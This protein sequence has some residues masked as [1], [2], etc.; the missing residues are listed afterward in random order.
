MVAPAHGAASDPPAGEKSPPEP[1]AEEAEDGSGEQAPRSVLV[2][3]ASTGIG[4]ATVAELVGRGWRVWATVRRPEDAQQLV[5]EHGTAVTVLTL[6]L[7]DADAVA[8]AGERVCIEG[9]L[10]GL[11]NN[12]GIAVPGP[13]EYLPAASLR[14]QLEVNVVAQLAVTQAVLPAL[15]E[16]TGRIVTIGSIGGRLARPT[17]GAYHTSKFALV[18]LTDTLRAELAPWGIRVVLVEPGAVA[19]PLWDRGLDS[20]DELLAALPA[21][22]VERYG[23]QIARARKTAKRQAR[24]GRPPTAV[25]TAVADALTVSRP[26]PRVLVGRDAHLGRYVAHLPARLRYRLLAG[27][28]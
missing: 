17:V 8:A 19:T 12:A 27:R 13:L 24:R 6:D 28:S 11:V 7:T 22:A 1:T 14:E 15:R 18:G 23:R 20:A 2:T 21:R 5:E 25:A 16:A 26:K 4:A 10:H 3:G 9:P